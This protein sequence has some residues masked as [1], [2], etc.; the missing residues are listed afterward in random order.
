MGDPILFN[1]KDDQLQRSLK[2]II[3]RMGSPKAGLEVIGEIVHESIQTNFEDGGRPE[4]WKPLAASTIRQRKKKGKWPGRMLVRS[5]TDGGLMGAIAYRVF[6]DRVVAHASKVYAA[7]HH[8]GGKAGKGRKVDI[9]A[10][11]YMM[12]Q[13]EDWA[14]MKAALSEYV[15]GL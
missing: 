10:R 9:P 8:F 1:C 4:K 7:I 5:G 13:D 2:G 15:F 12:V 3:K 14:E 11:P 6:N